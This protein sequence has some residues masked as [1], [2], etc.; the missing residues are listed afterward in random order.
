VHGSVTKVYTGQSFPGG[1][2]NPRG[3]T[4]QT[5]VNRLTK[6]GFVPATIVGFQ[7]FDHPEGDSFQKQFSD[8]L[9]YHVVV[10]YPKPDPDNRNLPTPLVTAH[11]HGTD[12]TGATHII[13]RI[14]GP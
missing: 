4:F 3:Q 14:V 8:G 2:I 11:C 10:N 5:A 6:N 9:W 7:S 13:N 1:E 12:P